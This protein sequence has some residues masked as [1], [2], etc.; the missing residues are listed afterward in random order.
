MHEVDQD[1]DAKVLRHGPTLSGAGSGP[2]F[3]PRP[4]TIQYVPLPDVSECFAPDAIGADAVEPSIAGI[5]T[6]CALLLLGTCLRLPIIIALFA[7][8]PFGATAIVSLGGLG[9]SSPLIYTAFVLMLLLT[10]ATRPRFAETIGIVFKRHWVPWLV[11]ALVIYVAFGAFFLPRLFT[12]QTMAFVPIAGEVVEVPLAPVPGNFTQTGYFALN[13][14][15]FYAF[16][17]ILRERSA[18]EAIGRG[19]FVFATLQVTLGAIDLGGKLVGL[20]NVLAPIRSASYAMLNEDQVNG[21]WRISGGFSEASAFAA[22]SV[23]CLAFVFTYWRATGSSVALTLALALLGLLVLSTSTTAY[24]A[25]AV[26]ILPLLGSVLYSALASR[27]FRR[28][29]M[30]AG[31]ALTALTVLIA[32]HM[33]DEKLL[34]PFV[35]LVN[36]MVF[37][38]HASSSGIQRAYWNASSL[39]SLADTDWLGVGMGSSRSS[40]WLVSVVSQLGIIGTVMM[41]ALV[42][43]LARGMTHLESKVDSKGRCIARGVRAASLASLV[44]LS[45]SGSS[46][47]PGLIFF[48]A[49]AML[50]ACREH[51]GSTQAAMEDTAPECSNV[52]VWA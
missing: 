46:A 24:V 52:G 15:A 23:S 17:V 10:V 25:L 32:V 12:D 47:D 26:L 37:E 20:N 22:A 13:V 50:V 35:D 44:T 9:G 38:K 1:F 27:I 34:N 5:L 18:L 41:A 30:L 4:A 29:L 14:L 39:Q 40:S 33:G 31:F 7:S 2:E 45:I 11:L 6:C 28:D 8:L 36:T 3:R 16:C 51:V 43:F 49:L 21:F 19:F 48:I 42:G